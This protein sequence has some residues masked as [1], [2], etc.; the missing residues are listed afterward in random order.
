MAILNKDDILDSI[1]SKTITLE[2]PEWGGQVLVSTMSGFAR[3]RFEASMVGKQG[4]ANLV[5]IR[6]KL[7]AATLVDEDGKLM[8]SESDIEKLGKKSCAALD[9]VFEA[10][11]KLNRLFDAD[12]EDLAGNS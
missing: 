6:A 2:V 9:R 10:S 1:D 4:G 8:F 5:N 11:Q 3:D 7:A 12:I